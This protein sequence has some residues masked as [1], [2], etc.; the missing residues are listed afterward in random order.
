MLLFFVYGFDD[1]SFVS[2]WFARWSLLIIL[3]C[4]LGLFDISFCFVLGFYSRCI[5]VCQ[6]AR[7][8]LY[9]RGYTHTFIWECTG[10]DAMHQCE[11]IS[12]SVSMGIR[13][14][15]KMSRRTT[16]RTEIF[17]GENASNIRCR[18]LSTDTNSQ[19][20]LMLLS[21]APE[22]ISS[23][24]GTQHEQCARIQPVSSKWKT[25]KEIRFKYDF[26]LVGV[27]L[28]VGFFFSGGIS[29]SF[30]LSRPFWC[31][32]LQRRLFIHSSVVP[33]KKKKKKNSR[34]VLK[35]TTEKPTNKKTRVFSLV[36]TR[37][38]L[39]FALLS[40]MIRVHLSQLIS[41]HFSRLYFNSIGTLSSPFFLAFQCVISKLFYSSSFFPSFFSLSYS[42]FCVCVCVSNFLSHS[43][44]YLS[45]TLFLAHDSKRLC[46]VFTVALLPFHHICHASL[47]WTSLIEL[48]R[49][50]L[51][52]ANLAQKYQAISWK[53][54][55]KS[56]HIFIWISYAI[57]S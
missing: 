31:I 23:N 54:S 38:S 11:W 28:C 45:F 15:S 30:S 57:Q 46:I 27:L 33:T 12:V 24:S 29:F 34:F 37:L 53:P 42:L 8:F 43:Q 44:T 47:S 9:T 17:L 21:K 49:T 56:I 52:V 14:N 20:N 50:K 39:S 26:V 55:R 2:R 22:T 1:Y 19:F 6:N 41:T 7:F 32:I 10:R 5:F 18:T 51:N 16:H 48:K 13:L 35:S 36:S 25:Q 40:S 4:I 3:F